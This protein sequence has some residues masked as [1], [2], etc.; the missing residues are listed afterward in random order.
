MGNVSSPIFPP[1][2]LSLLRDPLAVAGGS[3]LVVAIRQASVQHIKVQAAL[4][5]VGCNGRYL[6]DDSSSN[7]A[8]NNGLKPCTDPS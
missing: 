5:V 7:N 2:N 1:P 4:R 6:V 3:K 8:N